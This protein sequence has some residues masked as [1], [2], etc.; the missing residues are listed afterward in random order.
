M[1]VVYIKL[2]QLIRSAILDMKWWEAFWAFIEEAL[3]GDHNQVTID[4]TK[5]PLSEVLPKPMPSQTK[6]EQ[7]YDLSKSLLGQH[8]TLNENV[9]W[10]VGCM[11]AVSRILRDFGVAGVPLK[12]IEGTLQGLE[13]LKNSKQFQEIYSYTHGAVIISATT[14]GNGKVRGHVGVCGDQAIMSNNSET[15]NWDTQW[16]ITR[17]LAYYQCYGAIPTRYFLPV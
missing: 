1:A 13:F 14:T 6:A 4:H 2:A 15:G 10:M 8:L 9:P 17:W 3:S 11:E 5:P 7:L 16:N 12:G